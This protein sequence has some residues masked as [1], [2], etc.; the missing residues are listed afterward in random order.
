MDAIFLIGL[1]LQLSRPPTLQTKLGKITLRKEHIEVSL[2]PPV[3]AL[4]G[5]YPWSVV[6]PVVAAARVLHE[7]R[8]YDALNGLRD[9]TDTMFHLDFDD[10]DVETAAAIVKHCRKLQDVCPDRRVR[11]EI[12]AIRTMK[13]RALEH[14][15]LR[16]L[17]RFGIGSRL[18][19]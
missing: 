12:A 13:P 1:A 15:C 4:S 18:T 19:A 8:C 11:E 10:S 3:V 9:F 16:L 14:Y 6:P 5:N 7:G 17:S 2:G